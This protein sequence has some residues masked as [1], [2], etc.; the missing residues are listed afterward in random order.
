[1]WQVSSALGF[2]PVWLEEELTAA[3][4]E[5]DRDLQA[6]QCCG[7]PGSRVSFILNAASAMPIDWGYHSTS[8]SR[9][10]WID[11]GISTYSTSR[12]SRRQSSS[13]SKKQGQN[14][15]IPSELRRMRHAPRV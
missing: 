2:A 3:A 13:V 4:Q 9:G 15:L 12:A 6:D 7:Y 5:S 8:V 11:S 10:S 1:M 14:S